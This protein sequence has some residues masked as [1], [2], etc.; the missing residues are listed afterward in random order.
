MPN[1][2]PSVCWSN[3]DT[4]LEHCKTLPPRP[5]PPP[6]PKPPPPPNPSPPPPRPP[7][8]P[9]PSPPGTN[10]PKGT[11]SGG[12]KGSDHLPGTRPAETKSSEGA[13]TSSTATVAGVILIAAF[14]VAVI[15]L[16]GCAYAK[17][18]AKRG[19]ERVRTF[20]M[21]SMLSRSSPRAVVSEYKP[22]GSEMCGA[23]VKS[24][25]TAV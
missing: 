2:L 14:G 15:A 3:K 21:T 1:W 9:P 20:S 10:K 8:P 12:S 22:D 7:P 23:S 5:P 13:G 6:G 4:P 11:G 18:H 24:S 17:K 16:G 19:V 25:G